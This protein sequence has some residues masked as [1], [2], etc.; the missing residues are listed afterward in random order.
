MEQFDDL[1]DMDPEPS[2]A[3]TT[4]D[5]TSITAAL[6][7]EANTI[8]TTLTQAESTANQMIGQLARLLNENLSF[9]GREAALALQNNLT[10]QTQRIPV[11]AQIG[12]TVIQTAQNID[13]ERERALLTC[14]T[15]GG[16]GGGNAEQLRNL[17]LAL[18]Q[19][20]TRLTTLT[21]T[22]QNYEGQLK[23][24]T[25][26]INERERR[27]T[28][29]SA[30]AEE[31][32]REA[33]EAEERVAAV[34]ALQGNNNEQLALVRRQATERENQLAVSV[35]E[36]QQRI[37]DLDQEIVAVRQQTQNQLALK[38]TDVTRRLQDIIDRGNAEVQRQ[39]EAARQEL[40]RVQT[41]L[42]DA[43]NRALNEQEAAAEARIRAEAAQRSIESKDRQL[44]T[45]EEGERR[46][47]ARIASA[48]EEARTRETQL[49]TQLS[50]AQAEA[51]RVREQYEA[52]A[53]QNAE[54]AL[55]L[56]NA[57]DAALSVEFSSEDERQQELAAR[58][59]RIQELETQLLI[60]G[61]DLESLQRAQ[62]TA[63]S[64]LEN[65][66]RQL[67]NIQSR[68]ELALTER[69]EALARAEAAETLAIELESENKL[70]ML[71][72]EQSREAI[73]RTL[74][75]SRELVQ[76]NSRLEEAVR[77]KEA[78]RVK[79]LQETLTLRDNETVLMSRIDTLVEQLEE[80]LSGAQLTQANFQQQLLTRESELANARSEVEQLRQ[81][82]E[83]V[84][85]DLRRATERS[86]QLTT[87]ENKE[88]EALRTTEASS[89]VLSRTAASLQSELDTLRGA[90]ASITAYRVDTF[91]GFLTPQAENTFDPRNTTQKQIIILSDS[92]REF[93]QRNLPSNFYNRISW[94]EFIISIFLSAIGL[95]AYVT[96]SYA[97]YMPLHSI[98]HIFIYIGLGFNLI[99]TTKSVNGWRPLWKYK[100]RC[101]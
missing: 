95:A 93:L 90:I 99:G 68:N 18:Q 81:D 1:E 74:R 42:N 32:A 56:R 50:D 16:S 70:G 49:V 71:D 24:A 2:S 19:R 7:Q 17:Q 66:E 57:Q 85:G 65:T 40:L 64:T 83:R 78:D 8:S 36:K 12:Q 20:E 76:E 61:G 22:N 43:R 47:Q 80:R 28:E 27:I 3:I 86:Q 34:Q 54:L 45:R 39:Q 46:L 4:G 33:R 44:A 73:E 79:A 101:C 51:A 75:E 94:P 52:Q 72:L 37:N 53:R 38:E 10:I 21:Q 69:A 84:R 92:S 41:Q 55:R 14:G 13:I 100:T 48:N 59:A 25:Q 77:N 63:Q 15:G 31:S 58:N 26:Q 87:L 11:L 62:L 98:W 88:S 30:L 67:A 35:S 91:G 23:L 29:L 82:L 9:E 5:G 60:R 6:Q 89:L 97:E 96:D